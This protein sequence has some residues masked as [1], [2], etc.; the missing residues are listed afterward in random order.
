MS[1]F[2]EF[3]RK[4]EIYFFIFEKNGQK[5]PFFIFF[6]L[7]STFF[8][9]FFNF[10][11][12]KFNFSKTTS[13]YATIEKKP[14]RISESRSHQRSKSR[15]TK[16]RDHRPK[17]P[18]KTRSSHQRSKSREI[19]SHRPKTPELRNNRTSKSPR[20]SKSPIVEFCTNKELSNLSQDPKVLKMNKISKQVE[21]LRQ[22]LDKLARDSPDFQKLK[23]TREMRDILCVV[24][25]LVVL[26]V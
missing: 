14:K 2:L 23:N 3:F 26:T 20:K 15:E 9:F 22:K 13:P 4:F 24:N 6:Q 16:T 21:K 17:T 18:E 5:T 25:E 7:F 10:F 1:W 11:F 12:Q 19:A 8:N